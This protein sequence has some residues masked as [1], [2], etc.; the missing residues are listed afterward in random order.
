[1]CIDFSTRFSA[2]A[3]KHISVFK[4]GRIFLWIYSPIEVQQQ[5][6]VEREKKA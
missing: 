4:I 1:M 3:V 6:A 5:G 2:P